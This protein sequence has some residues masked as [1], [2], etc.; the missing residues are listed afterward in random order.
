MSS[1]KIPLKIRRFSPDENE[2]PKEGHKETQGPRHDDRLRD[3]TH[4]ELHPGYHTDTQKKPYP[5]GVEFLDFKAEEGLAP[6]NSARVC[7]D[8]LDHGN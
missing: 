3:I 8:G 1:E 5:G 4:D 6:C 2:R 7:R